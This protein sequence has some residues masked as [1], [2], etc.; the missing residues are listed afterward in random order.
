MLEREPRL[1]HVRVAHLRQAV[2]TSEHEPEGQHVDLDA[3]VH[4]VEPICGKVLVERF[5]RERHLDALAWI[6]CADDIVPAG[7]RP[8][9]HADGA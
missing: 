8:L 4:N 5:V 6:R 9:D 2:A 1:I 7:A 3:V